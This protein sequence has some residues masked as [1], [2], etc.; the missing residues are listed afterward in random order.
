MLRYH[1]HIPG[2]DPLANEAAEQRFGAYDDEGTPSLFVNGTTF[3]GAGGFMKEAPEMYG[4]LRKAVEPYLIQMTP[5]RIDLSATA[6]QGKIQVSAK[7][8]GL[9]NPTDEIKLRLVLAEDRIPFLARNGIRSHEMVVRAMPGGAEGIAIEQGRLG[10]QGDIDLATLKQRL[11][12]EL[13]TFEAKHNHRFDSKP[14]DLKAMH[15]VAF[16][17]DDDSNEILQAAAVPV[18]GSLTTTDRVTAKPS[19]AKAKQ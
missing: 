19:A 8:A 14:L 15:L 11:S 7:V 6:K 17:Q 5:V 4:R 13:A 16:V 1:Q 9:K 18:S 12:N 3:P 10:Y 2:P